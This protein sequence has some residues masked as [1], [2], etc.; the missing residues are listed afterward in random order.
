MS[1][2]ITDGKRTNTPSVEDL[3]TRGFITEAQR[4]AHLSKDQQ[5]LQK[6]NKEAFAIGKRKSLK[7]VAANPARRTSSNST[8]ATGNHGNTSNSGT[9]TRNARTTSQKS[10]TRRATATQQEKAWQTFD[11]IKTTMEKRG[12][13]RIFPAEVRDK[14]GKSAVLN[15]LN[16]LQENT[17][18]SHSKAWQKY[19]DALSKVSKFKKDS[20]EHELIDFQDNDEQDQ[21]F[22]IIKSLKENES[23]LGG[24]SI[25]IQ[26]VSKNGALRTETLGTG[27][28]KMYL[29]YTPDEKFVAFFQI[30]K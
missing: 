12:F 1:T 18:G 16:A 11:S 23:D 14:E 2:R 21:L 29:A 13:A 26:W 28:Q 17:S 9:S 3:Y 5:A 22:D 15:F 30:P 10:Q 6:A 7:C 20:D 27:K 24:F 19:Q 4:D 25:N 8:N